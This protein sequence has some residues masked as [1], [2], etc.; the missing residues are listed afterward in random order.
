MPRYLV[1]PLCLHDLLCLQA[2]QPER[3]LEIFRV[4]QAI[5]PLN[6]PT[7]C[8]MIT[9]LSR[10]ARRGQDLAQQAFQLWQELLQTRLPL[11][12]QSLVVGVLSASAAGLAPCRH[13]TRCDMLQ[14]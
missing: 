14:A 3:A 13:G 12:G 1:I 5:G 8:Q 6:L 4:M 7:W 11:D 2:G 10:P 9:V